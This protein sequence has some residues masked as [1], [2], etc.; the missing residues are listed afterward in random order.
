[1]CSDAAREQ[2]HTNKFVEMRRKIVVQE[3]QQEML[4]WQEATEAVRHRQEVLW[5]EVHG[6]LS[7][8]RDEEARRAK[9]L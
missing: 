4:V 8:I 9:A 1:M 3:Y 5:N 7:R 2:H 6:V